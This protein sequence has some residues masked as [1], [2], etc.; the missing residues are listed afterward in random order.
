MRERGRLQAVPGCEHT[1]AR[2]RRSAALHVSEHGDAGLEAGALL[3]LSPEQL[4]DAGVG[5][6]HVSELIDLPG[7]F[8]PGQ[9]AALADHDDREVLAPRVPT[10]DA[11]GDLF[12]VD[13]LL[14]DA[15]HIRAAGN[16]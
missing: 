4:A 7:V 11:V 2:S 9:F 12:E 1:V 15:D 8:E 14:R 10:A 6:L 5:A 13:R 3:D 16:S